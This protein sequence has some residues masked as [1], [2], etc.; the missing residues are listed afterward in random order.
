VEKKVRKK[1]KNKQ[2][3]E[4]ISRPGGG[5]D[6]AS[7]QG[8][9]KPSR[10]KNKKKMPSLPKVCGLEKKRS[11]GTRGICGKEKTFTIIATQDWD[12]RAIEKRGSCIIFASRKRGKVPT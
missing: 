7:I 9:W 3:E 1:E 11:K 10:K 8:T 4:L 12:V 6:L 5:E 2:R